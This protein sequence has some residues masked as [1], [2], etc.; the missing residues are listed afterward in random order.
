M[1]RFSPLP[2]LDNIFYYSGKVWEWEKKG[3]GVMKGD[4]RGRGMTTW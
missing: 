3:G 2:E 1:R 4:V